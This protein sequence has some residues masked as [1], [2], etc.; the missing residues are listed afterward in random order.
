MSI[1]VNEFEIVAPQPQIR[2]QQTTGRPANL[3]Q[4]QNPP[5]MRP[6]DVERILRHFARRRLRLWAD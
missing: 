1:I 6:E 2:E 5:E 4:Q 3:S